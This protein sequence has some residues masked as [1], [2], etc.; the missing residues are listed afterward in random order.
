MAPTTILAP[1]AS[2]LLFALC[3]AIYNAFIH[4]LA[5]IP[6][7][8]LAAISRLWLFR[9]DLS[10]HAH[11]TI[12]R[13]HDAHGPLIRIAPNEL[14]IRSLDAYTRSLYCQNTR[15]TKAPY[16][17]AAFDNPHGSVFSETGKQAHAAEK[18]LM[19][20]AFSRQNVLGLQRSVLY[21][22]LER[23]VQ[24]VRKEC[25]ER[26]RPVPLWLATQCL[27][28]ET[29]A[30]FS[31]GSGA[32]A[33]EAEGFECELLA[34]F[35]VLPKIVT[36]FQHWP[37]VRRV[38][39]WVQRLAGSGIARVNQGA[40]EGFDRLVAQK[41]QGETNGMIMFDSMMERATRN[42][43]P[44]DRTRLVNNGSLMLVAGTGTTAASLTTAIY[45]LVKQPQL[46][47]ELKRQLLEKFGDVS[48]Q[49]DVV[50]LE[51]VP[52]LEAV[53]KEA[54]RVGNP[55]RGRNPRVTPP[56]GWDFNGV[57]VP[58]GTIVSS[59]QLFYCADP[60][61]FPEPEKFK[62]ERW[63]VEDM[64]AMNRSLVVFSLGTRSCIG[65]N[66]ALIELKIA[67]S[68]IILNFNPGMT[69][70]EE[71]AFEEYVGLTSPKTPV[72]VTLY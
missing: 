35:E 50:E 19:A 33:F 52:L 42:G 5:G 66:L 54:L 10:G 39:M 1:L 15:F 46:W 61:A 56:G 30:C 18:R 72:E 60:S 24:R 14:S 57:H 34:G 20:H 23:W 12:Q 9:A 47:Y 6:G 22:N 28:L 16:F 69:I 43:M 36:V 65:Q 53:V 31:Y 45:Y 38:A 67:I 4:P 11:T 7:P 55:I 64:A 41:R 70:D 3:K 59:A 17:Y 51:K 48:S 68:Q 44:L 63:F 71:L 37:A 62:P 8:R 29:A 32:E 25:V 49:P 58:E 2:L 13:W 21:P 40:S 26:G 27:T